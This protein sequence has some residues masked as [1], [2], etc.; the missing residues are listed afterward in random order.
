M[1][2]TDK[3]QLRDSRLSSSNPLELQLAKRSGLKKEKKK[4]L[5]RILMKMETCYEI[6]GNQKL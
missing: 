1:I 2:V 3:K 5:H 4:M 6:T